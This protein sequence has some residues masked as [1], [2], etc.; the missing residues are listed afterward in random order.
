MPRTINE[1][2]P[3][4]ATRSAL[5]PI[6]IEEFSELL[7]YG[8]SM[9]K[10]IE[11]G[12]RPMNN[13]L[14]EKVH[15][16]TGVPFEL[17][18]KRRITQAEYAHIKKVVQTSKTPVSH[19][20]A[21]RCLNLLPNILALYVLIAKG[22]RDPLLSLRAIKREIG[23]TGA[24]FGAKPAELERLRDDYFGRLFG[25]LKVDLKESSDQVSIRDLLYHAVVDSE[26]AK[27][28]ENARLK[29]VRQ[30]DAK[31]GPETVD[32][33]KA[34]EMKWLREMRDKKGVRGV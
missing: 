22:G 20:F 14:A 12:R 2:N 16:R 33:K 25:P 5:G 10:Q 26:G 1:E 34:A 19:D 21:A 8:V 28:L 4:G 29:W 17:L 11:A 31:A 7:D 18:F 23:K 6:S 27:V 32:P 24:R 30:M 13:G 3:L 9:L 15:D